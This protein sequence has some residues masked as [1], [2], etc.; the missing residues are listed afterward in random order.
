MRRIYPAGGKVLIVDDLIATGGT[1]RAT[2]DLLVQGGAVP[3]GV[4]GVIGLPFLNYSDVL[5]DLDVRV[6]I[7]Y[8][9]E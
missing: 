5:K 2:A 3:V 9:G 4:F 6:L 7:E 1:L 8:F